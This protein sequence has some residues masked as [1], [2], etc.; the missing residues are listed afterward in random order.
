MYRVAD[1]PTTGLPAVELEHG[2]FSDG[3]HEFSVRS[4]TTDTGVLRVHALSEDPHLYWVMVLTGVGTEHVDATWCGTWDDRS[5]TWKAGCLAWTFHRYY[6]ERPTP[7][8]ARHR[9]AVAV[10]AIGPE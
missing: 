2:V 3:V 6:H 1:E 4:T 9:S 8:T 10:R 7:R 5:V